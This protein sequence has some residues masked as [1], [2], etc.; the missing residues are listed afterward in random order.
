MNVPNA[1]KGN[2]GGHAEAGFAGRVR[3]VAE[4]FD[5]QGA[6]PACTIPNPQITNRDQSE[7]NRVANVDIRT[8]AVDRPNDHDYDDPYPGGSTRSLPVDIGG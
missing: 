1:P 6:E 8:I 7:S 3:F 5:R 4:S 2:G